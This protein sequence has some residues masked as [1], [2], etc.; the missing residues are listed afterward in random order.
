MDGKRIST[1]TASPSSV[2][3]ACNGRDLD[4]IFVQYG[5]GLF[6]VASSQKDTV[7]RSLIAS[8]SSS[9]EKTKEQALRALC[10][11]ATSNHRGETY[12]GLVKKAKTVCLSKGKAIVHYFKSIPGGE[13]NH[14]GTNSGNS[15]GAIRA[16]RLVSGSLL[17]LVE[18]RIAVLQEARPISS[19]VLS[20]V[21]SPAPSSAPPPG[22]TGD[23][24][25]ERLR[26]VALEPS[27]T[28]SPVNPCKTTHL[29]ELQQHSEVDA[30]PPPPYSNPASAPPPLMVKTS[31]TGRSSFTNTNTNTNTTNSSPRCNSNTASEPDGFISSLAQVCPI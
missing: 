1:A 17:R 19:E 11:W 7:F 8:I 29:H 14:E 20:E 31:P 23:E 21:T 9:K 6:L 10:R 28:L 5:L 4:G 26:Q 16:V 3:R 2:R 27:R 22:G 12:S 18:A 13:G 15:G 30:P 25:G 24:V